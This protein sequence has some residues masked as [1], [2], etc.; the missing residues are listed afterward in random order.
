MWWVDENVFAYLG[1]Q[2][3]WLALAALAVMTTFFACLIP[4]QVRMPRP[5]QLH[6]LDLLSL[7][8]SFAWFGVAFVLVLDP[9]LSFGFSTTTLSVLVSVVCLMAI[10][11]LP[12]VWSLML[13]TR[14]PFI[15]RPRSDAELAQ[16][17]PPL[18]SVRE[19]PG[20]GLWLLVVTLIVLGL[21][22][23]TMIRL[24]PHPP[25]PDAVRQGAVL[26]VSALV[27]VSV[28]FALAVAGVKRRG[29]AAHALQ[30]EWD[31]PPQNTADRMRA[32]TEPVRRASLRE[33]VVQ[34]FRADPVQAA[35]YFAG[36]L[37][38]VIVGLMSFGIMMYE[39]SSGHLLPT[40]RPILSIVVCVA[41]VCFCL[42]GLWPLR[43]ARP[44]WTRPLRA[45]AWASVTLWAICV[46]LSL[47]KSVPL[48]AWLKSTFNA[49]IHVFFLVAAVSAVL[50]LVV[51]EV[52]SRRRR[53]ASQ[54]D[55]EP[56]E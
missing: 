52:A 3:R 53:D 32:S 34:R 1:D 45:I 36:I 55:E 46:V 29:H 11:F 42:S 10:S 16:P 50:A 13:A 44:W 21:P 19:T 39:R 35:L 5:W 6:A 17:L 8:P 43:H 2:H 56:P 7:P 22:V 54:A 49:L 27:V 30:P 14:D 48:S 23:Y 33:V 28:A 37:L 38:L 41:S 26:A 40:T 9:A 31:D 20:H 15:Q 24:H 47:P 4:L 18:R 12:F 25:I 51:M